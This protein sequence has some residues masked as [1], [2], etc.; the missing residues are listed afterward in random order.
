M[1]KFFVMDGI[2]RIKKASK[3]LLFASLAQIVIILLNIVSRAVFVR[4]LDSQYLGVSGLFSNILSILALADLGIGSAITFSLYKPIQSHDNESIKSLMRLYRKCYWVIG[5]SIFFIGIILLP[6][7]DWF[8]KERPSIGNLEF[9]YVLFVLQTSCIYFCSYK[10]EFLTATQNN[11]IIQQYKILFTCFQTSLQILYLLLFKE[12]IGFII[13]GI[14]FPLANNVYVS[15]LVNRKYPFLKEKALPVSKSD[16]VVI[17]KNVTAL[18]FYKV[19]QKLSATIDTIIVSK[20]MGIVEVALY[21]NYHFLLAYSDLLFIQVLGGITP[22]LGN[23][24]AEGNMDKSVSIFKV[25]QYI[26]YWLGIY[27]GVAFIVLFNPF[28]KIWLGDE[29]L[30]SDS[31]VIALAISATITNFQRP[32]SLVRDAGGLF[33]Y[34]RYRPVASAI[35]NIVASVILVQYIGTI[36]VIVGTIISKLATYAWF[37]PYIVYK[38][39]FKNGLKDYFFK[40]LNYWFHFVVLSFICVLVCNIN[41]TSGIIEIFVDLIVVTVI[42]NGYLLAIGRNSEEYVYLKSNVLLP[43]KKKI[44]K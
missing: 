5:S 19:A 9:I 3:N 14:I 10:T 37:D 16:I 25:V 7:I 24:F 26:Y 43:L 28:I 4:V 30:F 11:Y 21:S 17:K 31:I 6:N 27:F 40:Y 36:G 38:Y 33:W 2:S 44:I 34:G 15:Q 12:Y 1:Q 42:V 20:Y 35:I 39:K 13:L 29:Y 22:S 18:F 23:L 41:P 32:C 8:I